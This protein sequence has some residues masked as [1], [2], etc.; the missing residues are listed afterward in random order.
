MHYH[1]LPVV[2]DDAL[3]ARFQRENLGVTERTLGEWLAWQEMDAQARWPLCGCRHRGT[4]CNEH[5]LVTASNGDMALQEV[6]H[7]TFEPVPPEH[8]RLVREAQAFGHLHRWAH[9]WLNGQDHGLIA[10]LFREE[11]TAA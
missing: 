9:A 6:D 10:A 7:R 2:S 5:R 8:P 3:C 4:C 1:G 11:L